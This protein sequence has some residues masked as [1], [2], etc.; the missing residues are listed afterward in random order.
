MTLLP[1]MQMS[2]RP[3][4]VEFG[5]GH[6]AMDLLPAAELRRAAMRTL[7]RTGPQALVYGAAQGPG[8]LLE[9]IRER[10]ARIDG[11]ATAVEQLLITGGVS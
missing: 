7:E 6:P 1:A 5:W 3:G 11:R 9:L 2:L 8:R 10:L 4:C